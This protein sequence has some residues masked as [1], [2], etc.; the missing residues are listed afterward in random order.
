MSPFKPEAV[1]NLEMPPELKQLAQDTTTLMAEQRPPFLEI[2]K[3]L[4]KMK[5]YSYLFLII[6]HLR[7]QVLASLFIKRSLN[8]NVIVEL[9][10]LLQ[11]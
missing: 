3:R 7:L 1:N 8:Y 11:L 2:N 5:G 9:R 4:Q 10:S 6:A